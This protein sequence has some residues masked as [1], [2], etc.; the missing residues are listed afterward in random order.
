MII[1]YFYELAASR[2]STPQPRLEAEESLQAVIAVE[3]GYNLYQANCARC[4][5]VNG[6]GGQGPVLNDQMKLFSPP[7][8]A[9][10]PHGARG[11]R[12]VRLRQ[13]EERHAG[14]V[15]ANGGPL[16]YLQI[17]DLIA[18]IR[19]PNTQ[20]YTRRD[21]E[22]NEPILNDGRHSSRRSRA[23]ATR[24]SSR[25]PPRR[26]SRTAGPGPA[27]ALRRR[28]RSTPTAPVVTIIGHE[29]PA[30]STR[31]PST[32]EADTPFTLVFDN[33]DATA[34]HNVVVSDPGGDVVDIG[35]NA[36]LHR[37]G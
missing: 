2:S 28:R 10:H 31:P 14:L 9:V 33:Q 29:R 19:A 12:P 27:A 7:Q 17:E 32:V 13:P 34:P 22:L 15:A 3:R 20:E 30:P 23:G 5:G 4:H 35:E 24:S 16:N 36:V 37:P 25:T 11:R 18:F 26:P 6:E 1:Y 8:R 21:P